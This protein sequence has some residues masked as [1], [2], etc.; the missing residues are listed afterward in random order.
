MQF[1]QRKEEK[2]KEAR[3]IDA[4]ASALE[5]SDVTSNT[6]HKATNKKKKK[7]KKKKKTGALKT[8]ATTVS[9][10]AAGIDCTESAEEDSDEDG[11]DD[12]LRLAAMKKSSKTN[13]SGKPS[14]KSQVDIPEMRA[15]GVKKTNEKEHAEDEEDKHVVHRIRRSRAEERL[16][17]LEKEHASLISLF[18]STVPTDEE[19]QIQR[20]LQLSELVSKLNTARRAVE[21][22]K[23]KA[24][25]KR[26]P[27][28]DDLLSL[29]R[30]NLIARM[31]SDERTAA[32]EFG[33]DDES[34]SPH[35]NRGSLKAPQS[36]IATYKNPDPRTVR[37][38]AIQDAL[39]V[40]MARK[41]A[42]AAATEGGFVALGMEDALLP[43][44]LL[45][46]HSGVFVVSVVLC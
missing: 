7:K 20:V 33:D 43:P 13:I 41:A 25:D 14:M 26:L 6:H 34:S 15:N 3:V 28:G 42:A 8:E 30:G 24:K 39:A 37:Y 12:L 44:E 35:G 27:S 38:F 4:L 11:D 17:K 40:A 18:D 16:V 23:E 29:T 22:E 36:R 10:D 9:E 31:Q 5:A 32:L 2:E 1:F 45:E 19:D 21:I 46:G